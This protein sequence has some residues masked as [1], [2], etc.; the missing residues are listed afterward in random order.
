[1]DVSE[2]APVQW[3]NILRLTEA[4]SERARLYNQ[5]VNLRMNPIVIK[6][7][8]VMAQKSFDRLVAAI[9]AGSPNQ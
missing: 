3:K 2:P 1:M 5:A 6:A 4:Y 7:R 8:G 9:K